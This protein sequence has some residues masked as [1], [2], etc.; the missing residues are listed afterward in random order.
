MVSRYLLRSIVTNEITF[1]QRD[2]KSISPFERTMDRCCQ[3]LVSKLQTLDTI[4][5]PNWKLG[6]FFAGFSVG[7]D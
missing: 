2:S 6:S 7:V 3:G 5:F 4:I 1:N